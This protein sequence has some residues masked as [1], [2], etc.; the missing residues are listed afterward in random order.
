MQLMN[1]I[2]RHVDTVTPDTLLTSAAQ[3]MI[4]RRTRALAVCAE[5]RLVGVLTVHDLILRTT[6]ERRDPSLATVREVMNQ[7]MVR[8]HDDQDLDDALRLMRK[9]DVTQMWIVDHDG[10]LLGTVSLTDVLSHVDESKSH[11]TA[12]DTV[13]SVMNKT[14]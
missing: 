2:K 14:Q 1:I 11:G 3:K 9:K 13:E 10:Q 7:R 12:D 6:S 4:G 5:G 8:C